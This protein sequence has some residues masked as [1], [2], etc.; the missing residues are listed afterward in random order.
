MENAF[1]TMKKTLFELL[2]K[3]NLHLIFLPDVVICCC[4]LHNLTLNGKFLMLQL[5]H[6]YQHIY[7]GARRRHKRRYAR[8]NEV[9][10]TLE[11]NEILRSN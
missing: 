7:Q 4:M 2:L 1:G 10:P 11:D 5:E 8:S 3:N 9:E 6:E